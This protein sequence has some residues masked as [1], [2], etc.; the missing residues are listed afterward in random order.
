MARDHRVTGTVRFRVSA[1]SAVAA[2]VVLLAAGAVLVLAQRALLTESLEDTL[3]GHAA[4]VADLVAAGDLPEELV[5]TG[6]EDDLAQVVAADGTILLSS[7]SAAGLAP[8]APAPVGAE[9]LTRTPAPTGDPGELL[10]FS[11]RVEGPSGGSVVHLASRLDDV[12]DSTR[13][14]LVVLAVAIPLMVLALAA[15]TWWLVGRTLRPV[16]EIRREVAAIGSEPPGAG[17][18]PRHTG[19]SGP[20]GAGW[21][22]PEPS[23][24]DEIA[25]LAQ[26]MNAMLSRLENAALQERRFVADASHELRSPLTRMRVELELDALQAPERTR[27]DLLRTQGS[28]L[29]EVGRLQALVDDLLVLARSDGDE[30]P[31]ARL[32]DVRSTPID[33]DDLVLADAARL[34]RTTAVPIDVTG[35]SAAQVLG[36]AGELA[37]VIANLTDN[38]VRHARTEVWITVREVNGMAELTV[39]DDGPGIAPADQERVFERFARLDGGRTADVGGSGLGLAIVRDLVARHGGTVAVDPACEAGTRIVVRL[40]AALGSLAPVAPLA[41]RVD[42]AAVGVPGSPG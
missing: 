42:P 3:R 39:L 33:V 1:T 10:V 5:V 35:V 18:P 11:E 28:V 41:P 37:R 23:G 22:V 7:A 40:P 31:K 27:A 9:S 8:L 13:A 36:D 24:D 29:E 30:A 26:T 2:L 19:M 17:A 38:A 6:D 15:V 25:R 20:A 21:R 12:Q 16:E 34:R 4:E 14:L 32:D